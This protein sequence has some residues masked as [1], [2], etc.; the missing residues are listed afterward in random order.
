MLGFTKKAKAHHARSDQ[1]RFQVASFQPSRPLPTSAR[2]IS[3][4]LPPR[5]SSVAAGEGAAPPPDPPATTLAGASEVQLTPRTEAVVEAAQAR[6]VSNIDDV[7]DNS[8]IPRGVAVC[9]YTRGVSLPQTLCQ[10][11]N[12]SAWKRVCL[13]LVSSNTPLVVFGPTGCGKTK[14]L[15]ECCKHRLGMRPYEINGAC[16]MSISDMALLLKVVSGSKTLL[17]PRLVVFDDIEMLESERMAA[18]VLFLKERTKSSHP[19]VILC[20]DPYAQSLR[21][22]RAYEKIRLYTPE[23][24]ACLSLAANLTRGFVQRPSQTKLHAVARLCV[25][26]FH[27]LRILLN[28]EMIS[29]MDRHVDLFETSK[30]LMT[31]EIDVETW[32]RCGDSRAL[33]SILFENTPGVMEDSMHGMEVCANASEDLSFTARMHDASFQDATRA[34]S[35]DTQNNALLLAFIGTAVQHRTRDMCRKQQRLPTM[36]LARLHLGL[37]P[38]KHTRF[39]L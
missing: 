9:K 18:I 36:R 28:P 3:T 10:Y 4:R 13:H 17:G 25:G 1:T 14:G 32:S 2:P 35:Y 11:G 19:V 21:P 5:L 23:H 31:G 27:Q 30:R 15:D 7:F 26:N 38:P 33:V 24:A 16:D 8:S 39:H 12:Q 22:F 37:M 20:N 6:L 34:G 29:S